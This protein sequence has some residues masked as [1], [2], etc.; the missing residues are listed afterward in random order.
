MPLPKEVLDS[1]AEDIA[2]AEASLTDLKEVVSDM[3]LSGMDTA[4]QD[5]EVADLSKKLR[6][7]KMF[8]DLR[9]AKD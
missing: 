6:S 3:R 5:A 7:L 4:K 2:K 9:K 8:Y 1:I